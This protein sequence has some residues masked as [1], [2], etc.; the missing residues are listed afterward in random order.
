[1]RLQSVLCCAALV[2]SSASVVLAAPADPTDLKAK[3]NVTEQTQVPGLVLQP[4]AYSI[5]V[6]DH[7]SDRLI[8]RIDGPSN[9]HSTFLGLPNNG[10]PKKGTG[11]V[12]FNAGADGNAAA[13]GFSFPGGP[14]VEFV[15]P[16]ADAVALAKLNSTKVVAIDPASEGKVSAPNLS[17]DDMEVVTLWTLS[18]TTV[19][20]AEP[21]IKAERYQQVASNHK[22]AVGKPVVARLPHTGS[23]LPVT[24]LLGIMA[25]FG[26]GALRFR[27]PINR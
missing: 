14:G 3:F 2:A 10:L 15:Y 7:L 1:M 4:G 26:A 24:A 16:K 11:I 17:K 12:T 5:H 13:R 18:A 22:P 27:L 25:L 19:G 20:S 21:S 8:V 9:Q 23:Y 6:V